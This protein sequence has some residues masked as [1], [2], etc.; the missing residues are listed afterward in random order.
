M[1]EFNDTD[2]KKKKKRTNTRENPAHVTPEELLKLEGL[3]KQSLKDGYLPCPAAFKVALKARVPGIAIGEMTDKLGVR[4]IDCQIG[5]FKVD[6][7]VFKGPA[8]EKADKEIAG[9]L[10]DLDKNNE[11]TCAG[12]FALARQFN[13]TP[14]AVAG[15]ANKHKLKIHH[16]QLGC[17]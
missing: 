10:K 7:T 15:V 14:L 13:C 12:V 3:I 2:R 17:F 6:K 8:D 5:F 11:L 16:C 9:L 4:I 1:R